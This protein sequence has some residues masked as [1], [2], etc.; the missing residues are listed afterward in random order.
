MK[1][2]SDIK[3]AEQKAAA[4]E[5]LPADAWTIAL[6]GKAKDFQT[7]MTGLLR[8]SEAVKSREY[9]DLFKNTDNIPPNYNALAKKFLTLVKILNNAFR[10][11]S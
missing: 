2:I 1:R 4:N 3:K 8:L 9:D 11:N 7:A 10:P 5:F 6:N